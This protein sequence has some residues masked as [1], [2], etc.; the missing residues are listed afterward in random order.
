MGDE[1]AGLEDGLAI[2]SVAGQKMKRSDRHRSRALG[3]LHVNDRLER[4]HRDTHVGRIGRD[5]VIARAEDGQAAIAAGDRRTT[6]PGLA[7]V[8]GHG[9]VAKIH[10]AGSL[11]QI[12]GCRRHVAKLRRCTGQ[13]GLRQDGVVTLDCRMVG[14]IRIA[15]RGADFQ[16]AVRRRLD[17]VEWQTVDVD[18]PCRRFDIEFH[19]I[20]ERRPAGD[21]AHV[22]TLLRSFRLGAPWQPLL[23][24]SVGRINS[25]VRM[26]LLPVTKLFDELA[27]S[28][29]RY[30]DRH[31]SGRYC[32]SS[33]LSHRHR[34]DRTVP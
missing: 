2:R 10:A 31:R 26:G 27:E 6:C 18:E 13:D 14:E 11:Q 4:R 28:R 32:R 16:P 29:P 21:K 25:N 1:I 12:A 23:W 34:R 30:S 3:S 9:G 8:A 17:L 5:A 24:Q 15:D 33:A 7:L 22:C 20:D 19:Q